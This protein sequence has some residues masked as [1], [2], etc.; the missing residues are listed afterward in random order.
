MSEFLVRPNVWHVKLPLIVYAMVEMDE[1]TGVVRQFGFRQTIPLSP[2]DIEAL[3]M[4][5]CVG[6]SNPKPR[7]GA[8]TGLSL[9]PTHQ[10]TPMVAPPP[11]QYDSTYFG[12][13]TNPFVNF[14]KKAIAI[15]SYQG[16]CINC[17]CA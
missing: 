12:A 5:T 2:Q 8:K 9:T 1:S 11:G 6:Q 16:T 3:Y 14:I 7:L 10:E 13:F 17:M 4:S 15:H